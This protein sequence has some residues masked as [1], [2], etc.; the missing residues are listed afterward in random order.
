VNLIKFILNKLAAKFLF[1]WFCYE[2]FQ[3]VPNDPILTVIYQI[4]CVI[5][6]I[7]LGVYLLD[8][9][10]KIWTITTKRWYR[11]LAL[12]L[13]CW[14]IR[15]ICIDWEKYQ[16]HLYI[17]VDILFLSVDLFIMDNIF[18]WFKPNKDIIAP[19]FSLFKR[20]YNRVRHA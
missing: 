8:T 13:F 14:F 5:S 6:N 18:G 11:M 4:V 7:F 17:V 15:A 20:I 16:S 10:P 9:H 2:F 19:V 12:G 3:S 1:C